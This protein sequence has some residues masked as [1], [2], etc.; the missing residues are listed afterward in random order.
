MLGWG[1]VWLVRAGQWQIKHEGAQKRLGAGGKP[2]DDGQQRLNTIIPGKKLPF[3][4]PAGK[5]FKRQ[6][7]ECFC[8]FP[9]FVILSPAFL[10]QI[11]HFPSEIPFNKSLHLRRVN[12][13]PCQNL[14]DFIQDHFVFAWDSLKENTAFLM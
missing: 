4:N 2:R 1:G 13:F 9:V 8:Q 3:N 11:L 10:F 6:I 12:D 14:Q 5:L 7:E